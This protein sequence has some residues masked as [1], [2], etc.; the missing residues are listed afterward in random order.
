MDK[1][2]L[3]KMLLE[4]SGATG[5]SLVAGGD[6]QV[7]ILVVVVLLLVVVVVLLLLLLVIVVVP[8]LLPVPM[9]VLVLALLPLLLPV[10]T[11]LPSS[12]SPRPVTRWR[13]H[14]RTWTRTAPARSSSRNF[15][16][17]T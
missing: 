1:A 6:F 9:P 13:R 14:T 3:S 15:C 12:F 8:M 11:P 2:E 17:G 16:A 5:D 7:L 10:L 4:M